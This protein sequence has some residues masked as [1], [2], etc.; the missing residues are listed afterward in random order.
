MCET[1][2]GTEANAEDEDEDLDVVGGVDEGGLS[3]YESE[4]FTLSE[5]LRRKRL[6]KN[7]SER[8]IDTAHLPQCELSNLHRITL[9]FSLLEFI[10]WLVIGF[11]FGLVL[12]R[13]HSSL[14]MTS[15]GCCVLV[16][17]RSGEPVVH[18]DECELLRT[19]VSG[20]E[21]EVGAPTSEE[22]AER[23]K[24][25]MK[26]ASKCPLTAVLESW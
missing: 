17:N 14:K 13:A 6:G 20:S 9:A 8:V 10:C 11:Y 19:D 26:R 24:S 12:L 25:Q 21:F 18:C 3:G 15:R 5:I 16:Y 22:E 2:A 7:V 23:K 4:G 1:E